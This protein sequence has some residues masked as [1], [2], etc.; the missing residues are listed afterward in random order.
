MPHFAA[1]LRE[2]HMSAFIELVIL[3]AVLPWLVVLLTGRIE[4][5]LD[6]RQHSGKG[7]GMVDSLINGHSA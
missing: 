6:R 7:R 4:A 1:F 5:R 2:Q 3:P